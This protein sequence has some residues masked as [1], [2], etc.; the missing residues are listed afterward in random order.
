[1]PKLPC[2]TAKNAIKILEKN[3]F[4]LK[5]VTG[6]H[7]IFAHPETKKRVTVPYHDEE[8]AKGNSAPDPGGC[9]HQQRGSRKIAVKFQ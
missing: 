8:I 6:S 4:V 7:Y 9:R 2:L 1:M 5:R 3:G